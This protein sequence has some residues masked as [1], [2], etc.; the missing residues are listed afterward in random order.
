M[1][2]TQRRKY[3]LG[4]LIYKIYKYTA[5][6][7]LQHIIPRFDENVRHTS[8]PIA[9]SSR[10]I[11]PIHRNNYMKYS[12]RATAIRLWNEY[13]PS[14]KTATS[15]NMFKNLNLSYVRNRLNI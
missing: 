11:I 8:R 10:F 6:L 5:P 3:Y 4:N 9:P 12:F 1:T 15:L 2:P 14:L 7:Y 13:P